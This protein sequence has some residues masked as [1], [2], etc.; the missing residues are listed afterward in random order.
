[1]ADRSAGTGRRAASPEEIDALSSATRL[2]ILRLTLDN[3]M[4]N[5]QLAEHLSVAA[6]TTHYHVRKLVAAGLLEAQ[7]P[8]PR[9]A[10]GYEIPYRSN[11]RSWSL[12][13]SDADRPNAELLVAYLAEIA[14]SGTRDVEHATR[15]RTRLTAARK[16]E[17]ITRIRALW[18]EFADDEDGELW[19]LFFAIHPGDDPAGS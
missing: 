12:E 4:T 3:A 13:L 9:A 6:A 2:R 5:R 8:R 15:F 17:L 7:P 19:S 10:G 18:E 14:E 1:M 16:Q 11:G